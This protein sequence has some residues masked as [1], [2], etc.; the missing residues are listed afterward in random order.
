LLNAYVVEPDDMRFAVRTLGSVVPVRNLDPV[1]MVWLEVSMDNG[2]GMVRVR[3]VDM[4]RRDGGRQHEP[5]RDSEH[6][7]GAP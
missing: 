2:F 7:A 5:R 3:F 1:V 4:F 6:D